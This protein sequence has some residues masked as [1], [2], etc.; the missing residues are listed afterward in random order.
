MGKSNGGLGKGCMHHLR[1]LEEFYW[2]MN[3][4]E[5]ERGSTKAIWLT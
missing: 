2:E 4:K 1:I 5:K 3:T